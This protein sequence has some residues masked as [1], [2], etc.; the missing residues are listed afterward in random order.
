MVYRCLEQRLDL[1]I[2]K[3]NHYLEKYQ[4]KFVNKFES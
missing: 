4:F 2:K 3:Q 1:R